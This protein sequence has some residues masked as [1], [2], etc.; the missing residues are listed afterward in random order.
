MKYERIK[1]IKRKPHYSNRDQIFAEL[2]N[3]YKCQITKDTL[4]N[5]AYEIYVHNVR[6]FDHQ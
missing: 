1:Y 5:I 3:K 2:S 6:Q 4:K